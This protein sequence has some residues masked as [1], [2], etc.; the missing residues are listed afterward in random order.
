MK[1]YSLKLKILT[2]F[3]FILLSLF[4][5]N[6]SK[7]TT[8]YKYDNE[9]GVVGNQLPSNTHGPYYFE[10]NAP[11]KYQS[12]GI[13]SKFAELI[14]TD[15]LIA[16]GIQIWNPDGTYGTAWNEANP[17]TLVPGTTYYLGGFFRF[18]RISGNDIWTDL[19]DGN[20][21]DFDKLLEMVGSGFRW[22]IASGGIYSTL[23]LHKFTFDIGCA[24]SV[25]SGCTTGGDDHKPPNELGYS[26]LCDYEK[27]YAVVMGIEY[28]AYPALGRIRLWINGTLITDL[29]VCSTGNPEGDIRKISLNG[30]IGQPKYNAPAH[31]RQ[32]D[33][34]ILTDNWEDIVS[35]GYLSDPNGSSDTTPPAAPTG[36]AVE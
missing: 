33:R 31:R 7:A 19:V 15:N 2:I 4:L 30:T 34:I 5:C 29:S 18:E 12:D 10:L 6:S 24:S 36:L 25:F 14:T 9:D 8:W 3:F 16:Y 28:K 17:I 27:W 21:Y 22:I 13:R 26:Y 20:V 32:F 1:N 11:G 23:P 35:G